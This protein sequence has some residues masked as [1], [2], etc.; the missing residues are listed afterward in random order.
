VYVEATNDLSDSLSWETTPVDMGPNVDNG[1]GTVTY[2]Y[3][4]RD[5]VD[6]GSRFL[7]LVI[8]ETP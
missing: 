5:P 1:D 6:D 8:E 4:T 2:T 7:R 3:R